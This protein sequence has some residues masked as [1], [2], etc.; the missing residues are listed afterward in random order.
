MVSADYENYKIGKSKKT[1]YRNIEKRSKN[2]V[3]I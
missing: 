3:W 1:N 2:N